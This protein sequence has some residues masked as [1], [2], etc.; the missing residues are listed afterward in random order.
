MTPIIFVVFGGLRSKTLVFSGW[1]ANSSSSP[2]SSKRPLVGKGQKHGFPKTRFVPPPFLGDP[3]VPRTSRQVSLKIPP[4]GLF[5]LVF[6]GH[7][8][9]LEPPHLHMEGPHPTGR[10]ARPKS[11]SLGS[12]FLPD[13]RPQIFDNVRWA[14]QAPEARRD[15]ILRFQSQEPWQDME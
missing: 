5:S 2:F 8:E 7:T 12:L 6:E 3:E 11:L 15:E 1:T 13:Q 4:K 10:D 14:P 9:L